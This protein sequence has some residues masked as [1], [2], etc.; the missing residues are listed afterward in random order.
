MNKRSESEQVIVEDD[1][2]RK[3]NAASYLGSLEQKRFA[4]FAVEKGVPPPIGS[5]I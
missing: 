1:G 5:A 2:D 3:S 4:S